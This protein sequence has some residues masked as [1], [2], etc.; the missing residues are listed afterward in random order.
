MRLG[1]SWSQRNPAA[2][3]RTLVRPLRPASLPVLASSSVAY[4]LRQAIS[5][6]GSAPRSK[7]LVTRSSSD[8]H[9]LAHMASA[10]LR[11]SIAKPP[12]SEMSFRRF[13]LTPHRRGR[14]PPGYQ[15][16]ALKASHCCIAMGGLR[17][18][19]LWV[20]CRP[21]ASHDQA[22]FSGLLHPRPEIRGEAPGVVGPRHRPRCQRV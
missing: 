2:S 22:W 18:G 3:S 6:S 16:S 8:T 12:I 11:V 19:Q 9:L 13:I 15:L 14:G 1:H 7:C 5:A 21:G 17:R 20:N 4:A 10:P